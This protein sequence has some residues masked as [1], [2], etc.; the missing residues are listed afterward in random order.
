MKIKVK[1][2]VFAADKIAGDMVWLT[3]QALIAGIAAAALLSGV[4]AFLAG[5]A[6]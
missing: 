1:P 2:A 6:S 4:V 3:A 5:V